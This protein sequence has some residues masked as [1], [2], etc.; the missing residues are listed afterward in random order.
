MFTLSNNLQTKKCSI[1]KKEAI[2]ISEILGV[3]KNCIWENPNE[4]QLIIKNLRMKF[5]G[6]YHLP[7]EIP[8]NKQGIVCGDCVNNCQ[9]NKGEFGF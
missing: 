4:A 5:R 6:K 3:C 2:D 8:K 9:I 1:C 7:L